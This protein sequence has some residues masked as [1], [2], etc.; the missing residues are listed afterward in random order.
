MTCLILLRAREV[1]TRPSQSLLGMWPACVR[2][3]TTSPF[4]RAV[5]ERDDAAVDLRSHARVSDVGV[6]GVGEVDRS[7]V[8]RQHDHLA[9]R[10]EAVDLLRIQLHLERGHEFPGV[11]HLPLPL[12]ELAQPGDALIVRAG[13]LVAL[14]V[15]PV[16]GDSFLGDVMHFLGPDLHLEGM[17]A[18]ADDGSV[19]R[20]VQIGAGNRDEVFNSP[21]NRMPFVVDR[22]PAPRN[23]P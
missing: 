11:P 8:A 14:L 12:H 19:Q 18:G 5:P 15:L 7:R 1:L 22:R 13:A 16:G 17:T 20:L 6:D 4:R 10:R 21:G 9:A 23:S 2:I 3:S